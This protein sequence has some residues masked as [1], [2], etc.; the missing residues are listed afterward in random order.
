MDLTR[1]ELL[2]IADFLFWYFNIKILDVKRKS[3]PS[4]LEK[5]YR[6]FSF[7]DVAL[8]VVVIV[9]LIVVMMNRSHDRSY[10]A[11]RS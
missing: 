3:G 1:Y 2:F 5:E 8:I 6:L 7:V 9:V 10:I 11:T 4:A